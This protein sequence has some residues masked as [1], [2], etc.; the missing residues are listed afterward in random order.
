MDP[1]DLNAEDLYK[2]AYDEVVPSVFN[3]TNERSLSQSPGLRSAEEPHQDQDM[4]PTSSAVSRRTSLFSSSSR[5]DDAGFRLKLYWRDGYYW[6]ESR[7]ETWWCMSCGSNG[8]CKKNEV[9]HLV[10]N[11]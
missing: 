1:H 6:Q 8:H 5:N 9:M 11:I 7:K 4:V 10:I 2:W 3:M